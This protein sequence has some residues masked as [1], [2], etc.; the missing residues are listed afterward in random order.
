MAGRRTGGLGKGLDALIPNKA[1]GPS[2]EPAKKTRS[3]VVKKDKPTEKDNL[4][5]ERLVKISSVEPNLNQPRRHFDED[6]LLELSE[7][8][9]QYGVLQ[10]LLVSDKKDYFEIIAGER[11]WRAAKMAGLKEVPVVVKEF[12]D[13]EIVEISLIENIQR[14][15]LNPIEEAMA[16]K[17]LM[18]E[19]H[20][21]Q[22]EIAD[23]VAKSRTAVT[24]SMRLLKLSSKVQEMVIADMISAG[25]A[26]AL[27][28][29]SDEALQETTAMKVFD[30]KL[31]V[32]ETEK[33]VKNLVSPAKKIKT[34]RNTAEDAI[35][36]SL[37]EKMKG[38]M[39]TKVSI[40]RKKNNK[41]KIEIE[42]YSRDEL[43]RIIDLFESIR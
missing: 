33:L 17:R 1:G 38:I 42:Y 25:H 21:K 41:G 22:D 37:E 14:E 26:R 40:Q 6:A 11:R 13:Q 36:E 15:D 20:L 9:K 2:K 27:L 5:A 7:S 3:A 34:E 28:G 12:T 8:I 43:E 10:P 18:E 16:Y 4:A 23:R 32:R 35:Y 31:S 29:I 24:N 30:E 19:F 39:G